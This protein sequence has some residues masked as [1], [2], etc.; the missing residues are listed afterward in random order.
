MGLLV[1]GIWNTD[2]YDTKSTGGKFRR[3]ESQFR[4]WVT[5]DGKPVASVR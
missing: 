1:D 3:S 2:W 4:D 5:K